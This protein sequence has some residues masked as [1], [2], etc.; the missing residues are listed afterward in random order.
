MGLWPSGVDTDLFSAQ[1]GSSMTM[2]IVSLCCM[3]SCR[4][5]AGVVVMFVVGRVLSTSRLSGVSGHCGGSACL[6]KSITMWKGIIFRDTSLRAHMRAALRAT[7]RVG[8]LFWR[9]S[10]LSATGRVP[11]SYGLRG[12]RAWESRSA[13]DVPMSSVAHGE[14]MAVMRPNDDGVRK[15]NSFVVRRCLCNF[16]FVR[17]Q[18][19]C[20][21]PAGTVA[22]FATVGIPIVEDCTAGHG[23]TVSTQCVVRHC[24]FW[25]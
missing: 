24:F 20:S 23:T 8:L 12:G 19:K 25:S 3:H 18:M 9:V 10:A 5:S 15:V 17:Y 1:L 4:A 6:A 11:C 22:H 7:V 14:H 21:W 16:T 2:K 13:P